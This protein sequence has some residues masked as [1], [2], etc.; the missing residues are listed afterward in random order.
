MTLDELLKLVEEHQQRIWSIEDATT[1]QTLLAYED[2]RTTMRTELQAILDRWAQ[3]GMPKNAAQRITL[4]RHAG[5]IQ[6]IEQRIAI[7]KGELVNIISAGRSEIIELTL[8]NYVIELN[9][10]GLGITFGRFDPVMVEL[11]LESVIDEVEYFTENLRN[12]VLFTFR[13]AAIQGKDVSTITRLLLSETL[14][15]QSI[16][17]RSRSGCEILTRMVLLK[18]HNMS[19]QIGMTQ[20]QKRVPAIRKQ[21]IA[22]IDERTTDC[23]LAIH[24]KIVDVGRPFKTVYGNFLFPPFHVRCRTTI[25]T[26]HKLLDP[27][28]TSTKALRKAARVEKKQR[29]KSK[30]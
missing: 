27:H 25:V 26:W 21:A 16:W 22:A 30:K 4:A 3:L 8:D 24:G 20:T 23:C 17:Q 10:I 11:T 19:K 13:T 2:A 15:P 28:G 12:K 7:L 1:A 29:A 5:I 6:Q 18:A 9:S 14:V